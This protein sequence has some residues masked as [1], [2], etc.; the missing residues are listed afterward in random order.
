MI[1]IIRNNDVWTGA[2]WSA[3]INLKEVCECA[4]KREF[5]KY[6]HRYYTLYTMNQAKKIFKLIKQYADNLEEVESYLEKKYPKMFENAIKDAPTIE[7]RKWIPCSERL[8]E[9]GR[10]VLVFARS[11]HFAL[12][13]YDEMREADGKYKKQWVTFDAWKPFYTI[14]EVIA[15]MPLPEP[16]TERRTDEAY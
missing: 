4:G 16:Y 9:N 8:P 3:E 12:A 10:Q 5:D 7:E 2:K 14:K 1:V 15:W 6:E 13:K 11:V